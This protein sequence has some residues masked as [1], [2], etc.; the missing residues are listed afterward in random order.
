MIIRD[1]SISFRHNKT[2]FADNFQGVSVTSE[3]AVLS[4]GPHATFVDDLVRMWA[5]GTRFPKG[6]LPLFQFHSSPSRSPLITA[7]L[8]PC[9][10]GCVFHRP[11][12]S[13][14]RGFRDRSNWRGPL[15]CDDRGYLTGETA[16]AWL[17]CTLSYHY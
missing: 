13:S 12:N 4:C 6:R 7:C 17:G 2:R 5:Y 15:L 1:F 11:S 8:T 9:R 10:V 14:S 3:R 16:N